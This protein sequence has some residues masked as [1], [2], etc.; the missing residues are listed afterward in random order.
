[1]AN[2]DGSSSSNV[3]PH[4]SELSNPEIQFESTDIASGPVI[5]AGASLLLIVWA[6]V[7]SLYFY[8]AFLAHHRNAVGGTSLPFYRNNNPLPPNPRIQQSPR[9]HLQEF[10]ARE[11]YL[12]NHYR[13]VD[14]WKKVV[15]LP[16]ETAI[17]IVARRGLPPQKAPSGLVL[18]KPQQ[19]SRLTGFQ[20]KVEPEPQ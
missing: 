1:M 5:F 6:L 13:W 17:D 9:E 20:G 11:D 10:R 14:R 12:L 15:G 7:G 2:H 3:S 4:E 18:S 8:F 16:I 19:G